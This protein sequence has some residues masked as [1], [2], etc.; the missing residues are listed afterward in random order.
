MG[1]MRN[2]IKRKKGAWIAEVRFYRTN[3]CSQTHRGQR[4]SISIIPWKI[5]T[6]YWSPKTESP[7][8]TLDH[9]RGLAKRILLDTTHAY[10]RDEW[11]TEV[12]QF[13]H[14]TKYNKN[15]SGEVSRFSPSFLTSPHAAL[16][17][18]LSH[19]KTDRSQKR[20]NFSRLPAYSKPVL[21]IVGK[22]SLKHDGN[23]FSDYNTCIPSTKLHTSWR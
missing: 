11:H 21:Q 1:N 8:P 13:Y 18:S 4:E 15:Q 2:M 12:H 6:G 9:P 10:E 20:R 3:G 23:T 7:R 16:I 14:I 19:I 22:R 17:S 5:S